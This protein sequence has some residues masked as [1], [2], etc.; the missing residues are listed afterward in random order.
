MGA[1]ERDRRPPESWRKAFEEQATDEMMARLYT[2]AETRARMIQKAARR[3]DPL[4]ARELVADAMAD[5]FTGAVT[6][7]PDKASLDA[8]LC[9]VIRSKS[10]HVLRHAKRFRYVSLDDDA[11]R[12]DSL[13]QETSEAMQRDNLSNDEQAISVRCRA[14]IAALRKLAGSDEPVQQ[15]LA[16]LEQGA[17][18]RHEIM[19]LTGMKSATYHNARRRLARLEEKLP[20]DVRDDA[21]QVMA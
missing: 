17:T 11:N 14:V 12:G 13:E 21:L 4:V 19:K 1:N 2:Y 20:D 18:E 5:T 16:A 8:H 7:D 15:I 3:K 10:S 6:W 9:C